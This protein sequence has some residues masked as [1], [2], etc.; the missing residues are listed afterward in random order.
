VGERTGRHVRRRAERAADHA[1]AGERIARLVRAADRRADQAAGW[2][3][4]PPALVAPQPDGGRA[5]EPGLRASWFPPVTVTA[6]AATGVVLV[7]LVGLALGAWL[8]W[9]GRPAE[10]AV[11]AVSR[12][13][14]A[15]ATA[16][17]TA[18]ETASSTSTSTASAALVVHVAGEVRRPGLVRL[19]A[20][21]R[22][23]DAVAAA[24][25]TTREAEPAS[26]NLA[27][28][29]V[30]GEQLVVLGE[31]EGPAVAPAAPA[32]PGT[33]GATPSAPVDLNTATQSDLE[34]LPGVGPVLAQRILDWRAEHGR[35]SSVGE[36]REI[37][38][39]GEATFADL[40]PLVRV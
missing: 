6:P 38:G 32:A 16:A 27:R 39:I 1:I 5:P 35:F 34:T 18:S 13:A 12:S 9:R 15:A 23:A 40:E 30:D 20:G 8:L 25:G 3:P 2:V 28:P 26:V 31:G 17:P 19:P 10:V 36:L 21:S 33:G 7:L 22:V 37:S 4:G 14:P 24:G 29:L 11:P